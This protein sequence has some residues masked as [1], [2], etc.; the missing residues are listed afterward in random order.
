MHPNLVILVLLALEMRPSL[1][2]RHTCQVFQ[3]YE[4]SSI[5]PMEIAKS[6]QL[7]ETVGCFIGRTDSVWFGSCEPKQVGHRLEFFKRIFVCEFNSALNKEFNTIG[8]RDK[9]VYLERLHIPK[10]LRKSS[11][12][13]ALSS[14]SNSYSIQFGILKKLTTPSQSITMDE[15]SDKKSNLEIRYAR[16][17][18][19][20]TS[21]GTKLIRGLGKGWTIFFAFP[22]DQ[23]FP[24]N[25]SLSVC[26][27]SAGDGESADKEM[28]VHYCEEIYHNVK[29]ETYN[30]FVDGQN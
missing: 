18:E 2:S 25:F 19:V 12:S 14:K 24:I 1:L 3:A 5:R 20:V 17:E 4:V 28:E 27:P 6:L 29:I 30:V 21:N 26:Y 13:F 16:E 10:S 8:E 15:N 11:S 9:L 7:N 22:F 23:N